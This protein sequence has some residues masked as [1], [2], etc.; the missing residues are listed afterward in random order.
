MQDGFKPRLPYSFKK[1]VVP[2]G[3]TRFLVRQK[4]LEPPTY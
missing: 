1:R 2:E 4:G 3:T